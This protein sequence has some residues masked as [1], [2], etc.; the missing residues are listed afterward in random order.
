MDNKGNYL[1]LA[2][3]VVSTLLR[4]G[5]DNIRGIGQGIA[6]LERCRRCGTLTTEAKFSQAYW[7]LSCSQTEKAVKEGA[8]EARD[9]K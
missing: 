1:P 5:M 9:L 6:P 8:T 7:C 2:K 3:H 4:E